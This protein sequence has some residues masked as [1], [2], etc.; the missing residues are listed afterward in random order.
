MIILNGVVVI[1]GKLFMIIIFGT[2]LFC[3]CECLSKWYGKW[4]TTTGDTMKIQGVPKPNERDE[5][6]Q[7]KITIV[8]FIHRRRLHHFVR[9]IFASVFV[10]FVSILLLQ[11]NMIRIRKH[12][13]GLKRFV[14]MLLR[15]ELKPNPN[16]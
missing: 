5:G 14:Y 12:V 15:V 8:K 4:R 6:K 3:F 16:S 10:V 2:L 13:F 7:K 9:F 11:F 1:V